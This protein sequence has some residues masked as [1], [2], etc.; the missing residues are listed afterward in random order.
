MKN[1]FILLAS[2]SLLFSCGKK[3][4]KPASSILV[5]ENRI[6]TNAEM[7]F[8]KNGK[9]DI[10]T[11][12]K[13]KQVINIYNT[14]YSADAAMLELDSISLIINNKKKTSFNCFS[15][16]NGSKQS[17][18]CMDD[19]SGYFYYKKRETSQSTDNLFTYKLSITKSDSLLVK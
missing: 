1:L 10:D 15:F 18:V 5:V 6:N 17:Q 4:Y 11:I 7:K 2:C 14:P 8:Y 19:T 3:D 16:E 9:L 13:P 12:L